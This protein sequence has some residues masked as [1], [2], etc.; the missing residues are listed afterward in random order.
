MGMSASQ[1]RY[2][3]ISGRKSDVEFQGQ[4]INQQ[5]T[6]LAT[7]TS[8]YNNQLMNLVVPTPP[9]T[10]DYTKTSYTFNSNGET[11]TVSG[12]VYDSATGTYTVNYTT[13]TTTSQGKSSGTSVFAKNG[14]NYTTSSGTVLSAI[15]TDEASPD[16]SDTDI[17]NVALIMKNCGIANNTTYTIGSGAS[18]ITLS[19]IKTDS[20]ANGYSAADVA[21][22]QTIYGA[23]YNANASYYKYNTGAGT[24]PDP[25]VTH[26]VA[27]SAISGTGTTPTFHLNAAGTAGVADAPQ[28]IAGTTSTPDFYKYTSSGNTK[29]I[30][31]SDL[32]D[33]AGTTSAVSTYYVDPEATVKESAKLTG[34]SVNW[35][36]S[37]RMTSVTDANG[38]E[39][40]LNVTTVE[41]NAAYADAYNEYEYKK[42]LYDQQLNNINA[43][44]SVIQS[45]D[46]TLELKLQDLDTQQQAL[47][48]EM[49]SV[50]KVLDKNIETSFKAF[51]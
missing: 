29:Y 31:E 46:K 5:R 10:A 25:I 8:A 30:L 19:E 39:Y 27:K 1:M 36:D 15:V 40:S 7:E 3:M 34:A 33:Y 35:N 43:G 37:G 42:S 44:V 49:D 28:T 26:Y 51:A 11:R 16:Y 18:Q 13:D 24:V 32:Q 9:S 20:T 23:G 50:K 4:Q 14:S 48:T 12:T 38:N 6:T 17:S 22:L 45:Q 41:D 21:A 2:C 47:N